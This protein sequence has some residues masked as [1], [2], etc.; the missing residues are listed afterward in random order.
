MFV[1]VK[2]NKKFGGKGLRRKEG[3][4]VRNGERIVTLC[5]IQ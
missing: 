3:G 1:K 5:K 4:C 2:G